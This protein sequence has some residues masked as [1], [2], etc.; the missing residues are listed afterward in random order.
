[1]YSTVYDE[2]QD[3]YSIMTLFSTKRKTRHSTSANKKK[4]TKYKNKY[5]NPDTRIYKVYKK[6]KIV[7]E[8]K[9]AE[10]KKQF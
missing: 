2:T 7:N 10:S 9:K 8:S 1:M 6:Q 3:S 4:H 5:G